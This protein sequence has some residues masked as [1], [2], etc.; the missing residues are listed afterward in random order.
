MI[1]PREE[2][3]IWNG[4]TPG[5]TLLFLGHE[6]TRD[7]LLTLSEESVECGERGAAGLLKDAEPEGLR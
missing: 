1:S 6:A 4:R 5:G 7:Q 2:A 3:A